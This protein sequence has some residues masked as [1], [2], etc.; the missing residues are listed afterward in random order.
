MSYRN[1]VIC[2]TAAPAGDGIRHEVTMIFDTG[3]PLTVTG[4]Q[5]KVS[6]WCRGEALTPFVVTRVESCSYW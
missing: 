1:V 3:R 5:R 6:K 2:T 4:A